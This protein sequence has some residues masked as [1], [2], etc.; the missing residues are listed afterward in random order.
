MTKRLILIRHA[1]SSWDAPFDD[2]ARTLNDKGRTGA[3]A[4]GDWLRANTYLPDEI[5]S[6]DAART[7]ETT[8]VI[9]TALGTAPTIVLKANMYHGQPAALMGVLQQAKGDTV[10]LVAHN[11][12][13]A[14]FAE[15]IVAQPPDHRRFFDYPTCATLVCDFPINDWAEAVSRSGQVVDFV[16]PKDLA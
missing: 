6:S 1:K 15:Q 14:F 8:D 3:T 2:H 12:G 13:I 9:V 10:A 5:Y 4:V 11:P 16:V 7:R